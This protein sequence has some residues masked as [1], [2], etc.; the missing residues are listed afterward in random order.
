MANTK[1]SGLPSAAVLTGAELLPVVQAG[2]TTQATAAQI[3][4]L[5][6][7]LPVNGDNRIT[8]IELSKFRL[9]SWNTTASGALYTLVGDFVVNYESHNVALDASGNFLGRDD[10][11]TCE[12]KAQTEGG[13]IKTYSAVTAAAGVVPVFVL[14]KSESISAG[15]V[16][17]IGG[18]TLGTTLSIG[19]GATGLVVQPF[20]GGGN[21]AI[22]STAVTPSAVNYA[23][24]T[25]GSATYLNGTAT[26]SL[27][28]NSTPVLTASSTGAA[29]TGTLSATGAATFGSGATGLVAMPYTAGG[30]GA[31]YS[32]SVTPSATN[33]AMVANATSVIVNSSSSTG[34]YVGGGAGTGVSIGVATSNL[35]VAGA[36]V[37]S[38]TSTGAAVTGTLSATTTISTGGYTVATL[39]AG[40]VGQRAYVTDA[41]APTFLGVLT[42][43]GAVVT[44]VFRNATVW[45]AN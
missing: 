32:T 25:S 33:Y 22:Y 27:A 15:T 2:V 36:P 44:P 21:G 26:S 5:S 30:Y 10:V 40:T 31:L 12:L 34:I 7:T 9:G 35:V 37:V 13:L 3:S 4:T 23:F 8:G 43:G 41:L 39:P 11:G 19:G 20:T 16:S 17:L 38:A 14:T 28:V 18:V 45:V 1:I 6:N 29:V 42:G 24:A